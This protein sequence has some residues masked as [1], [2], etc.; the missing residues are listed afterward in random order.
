MAAL[1]K[2]ESAD[3]QGAGLF[4]SGS[5]HVISSSFTIPLLERAREAELM[6]LS[7]VLTV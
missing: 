3:V 2:V 6:S 7:C 5:H 1:L 4:S